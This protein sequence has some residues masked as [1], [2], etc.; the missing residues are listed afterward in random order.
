MPRKPRSSTFKKPALPVSTSASSP[1]SVPAPTP[2]EG[3]LF[4]THLDFENWLEE[5]QAK[6]TAGTWILISKKANPD[7]TTHTLTYDQAVDSALCFGWIDGQ[8]RSIPDAS[9]SR[10]ITGSTHFAQR[11]TPRR[12]ASLWSKRNVDKITAFFAQT[13]CPIR[14]AGMAQIQAA[15]DDGRWERAYAGPKDMLVP[16]DLEEAI[17]TK[18]GTA[19]VV[20]EGLNRSQ[21]YPLLHKIETAKK[22]E[23]RKKRIEQIVEMLSEG[24][25]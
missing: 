14:P 21:R 25:F 5:N 2:S 19:D 9:T 13:P 11:F 17:R 6:A 20:F 10:N 18:G 7:P 24:K 8:R 12:G 4:P 22:P 23:T 1:S 15:K 16:P 3:L